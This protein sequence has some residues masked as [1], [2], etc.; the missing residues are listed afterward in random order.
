[1]RYADRGQYAEVGKEKERIEALRQLLCVESHL[2]A[3]AHTIV[4][5]KDDTHR[6]LLERLQ[7]LVTRELG[8]LPGAPSRR[9]PLSARVASLYTIAMSR[10]SPNVCWDEP[11]TL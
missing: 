7:P 1:M 5:N 3:R 11:S 4:S 2:A 6:F 10:I 8:L 9:E